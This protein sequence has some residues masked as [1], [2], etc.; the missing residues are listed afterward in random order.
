MVPLK[1]SGHILFCAFLSTENP[2]LSKWAII[3]LAYKPVVFA[4]WQINIRERVQ[5]ELSHIKIFEP[6]LW[7]HGRL[8]RRPTL[9]IR[10]ALPGIRLHESFTVQNCS[11]I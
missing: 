4:K 3:Y 8:N 2:S 6:L 5:V 7:T 9:I 11:I 1:S 10:G